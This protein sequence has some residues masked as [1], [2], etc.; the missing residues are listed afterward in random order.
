M[1]VREPSASSSTPFRRRIAVFGLCLALPLSI[2][3][4]TPAETVKAA[5][6]ATDPDC[7]DVMLD[8]P[9]QLDGLDKRTTTSQATAAWGEP[10]SIILRCGTKDIGATSDPC[11]TVD[12]VDWISTEREDDRWTLTAYGRTPGI[13][14]N[15]DTKKVSSSNVAQ[16]LSEAVKDLEPSKKCQDPLKG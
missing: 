1:R 9:K 7:A 12:G 16:G 14:V 11:T 8:L 15:L 10:A 2:S 5:P 4:C 6:Q 13:Q 3:A